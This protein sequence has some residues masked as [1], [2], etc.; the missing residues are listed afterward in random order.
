M[1]T[2]NLYCTYTYL[3]GEES[4]IKMSEEPKITVECDRI[5]VKQRIGLFGG[6]AFVMGSVIGSGIF[7]SPK[8][9]LLNTGSIGLSLLVWALCGVIAMI[10]GLV[11]GELG[12]RVPKSGGDYTYIRLAFGGPP[13]FLIMWVS[14]V[15]TQPGS[16]AILSLV[17][18]DYFCAPIFTKCGPSNLIRKSIAVLEILT[19]AATNVLSVRFAAFM[20]IFFTFAKVSALIVISIGGM[21]YLFQGYVENLENAF[22]GS[23]WNVES[24]CLA[25]YSCVWAYGGYSNINDIAEEI[26]DPKRNIP[27]AIILS[28]TAVTVIYLTT[29]VS[30]STLLPKEEFVS[31]SAVAFLWGDKVL[32]SAA[33][34][35][36][37]SV[38]LSVH[39]ASNGGFFTDSRVRF[40]AARAGHLPE[41][42][43]FLHPKSRIPV[44]SIVFNTICSIILLIP[45]DIG[46]LINMVGFLGF[47]VHGASTVSLLIFRYRDQTRNR[48]EF[49]LP[50]VIPIIAFMICLFMVVAPFVSKPRI[51][52]VYGVAF[53]LAGF[54]FYIPFVHFQL[55]LPGFDDITTFI[56]LLM[57]VCPTVRETDV[58][59]KQSPPPRN[60]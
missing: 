42:L 15:V 6:I 32:R 2:V 59:K 1:Y 46:Q 31:A 57:N 58:D 51:E 54:L 44:T 23:N 49:S 40:A 45:A 13:A 52:F 21:I 43:S 10:V 22:E 48:K 16:R 34:I 53:L 55:S 41:V 39:G 47:L 33:W 30:Y 29:N 18:A 50:V 38:M 27:R 60:H 17:F 12:T 9:A 36:P 28:M 26:I 14:T 11:Y 5:P 24:I 20:Q 25:L 19:L 8:G 56:Q 4:V 3:E 7:I 35:I 37:I